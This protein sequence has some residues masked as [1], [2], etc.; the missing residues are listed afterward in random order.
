[1]LCHETTLMLPVVPAPSP[2]AARER[3]V[4]L[5]VLRAFALLGIF[6]MN[7]P[8]M[9]ES[10]Y[11]VTKEVERWP[12]WY[13]VSAVALRT[14]LFD[15]KFNSLFTLLFGIGFTIQLERLTARGGG[16]IIYARRLVALLGFGVIHMFLIWTGDVLHMYA[17]LGTLLLLCRRFSDRFLIWAIVGLMALPVAMTTVDYAT[18]TPQE[19]NRDRSEMTALHD[20]S[21]RAYRDGAYVDAVSFRVHE[22]VADYSDPDIYLFVTSLFVTMLLGMYVGRR[23]YVQMAARHRAALQRTLGWG[24]GLGLTASC[25]MTATA[26]LSKPFEAS[27]LW[28]VGSAAYT[29]QRPA[30]MLAYAAG[31]V[32]LTLH[33]R[34]GSRL[35]ALQP[36]GRMPLTNYLAQSIVGTLFFYGYGFGFYEQVGPAATMGLAVAFFTVQC[37]YSRWWFER[38]QFGPVEALWRVLTYGRWPPMRVGARAVAEPAAG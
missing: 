21:L 38:F 9:G 35:A 22:A 7:L 37:L 13:D 6:V 33:P 29:V 3:V 16:W 18:Y 15:G 26:Y 27:W 2:V 11:H 14:A 17:V 8:G 10:W 31:I 20:G 1:M 24:L 5:D 25:T 28:I 34:W 4:A 23:R 36:M 32:L 19:A 30:L 12:S